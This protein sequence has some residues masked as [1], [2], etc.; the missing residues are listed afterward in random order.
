MRYGSS[1]KPV[2]RLVVITLACALPASPALTGDAGPSIEQRVED[3]HA[4]EQLRW[5]HR[6][7]PS[8]NP[9]PRPAYSAVVS[10]SAI[11]QAVLDTLEMSRL[12]EQRWGQAPSP[13]ELQGEL[14]RMAH[15]S[16]HPARLRELFRALDDDP[17]RI[18]ESL[19]RPLLVERRAR[20]HYAQDR[21]IHGPLQQRLRAALDASPSAEQLAQLGGRYVELIVRADSTATPARGAPAAGRQQEAFVGAI[22]W[23]RLRALPLGR[24]GPLVEQRDRFEVEVVLERSE[25][26]LRLGKVRWPKRSFDSWWREVGRDEAGDGS[27]LSVPTD[28]YPFTLPVVAATPCADPDSWTPTSTDANVPSPREDHTAV[29]TGSEMIV[30]GGRDPSALGSGGLYDPATDSWTPTSST[31][32][33]TPRFDHT[34]VWTGSAMIVWGGFG[35]AFENSGASYDPLGDSWTATGTVGAPSPRYRQTV[36]WT[37][38]EMIVWGGYDGSYLSSGGR[39][40]PGTQAWTATSEGAG[41][42]IARADH[43]AVWSGAEMIVW[44]G[45][46]GIG[47]DGVDSGG[48][49]DPT[50][51]S[52]VET[53]LLGDVPEPRQTHTI[54]SEP[55]QTAVCQ[56][57]IDGASVSVVAIQ[58]SV[59]GS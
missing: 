28:T 44:G 57:R 13:E 24:V 51:D 8:Q 33:P 34:A 21:R 39:Y 23:Q 53:S 37:G 19:A 10:D 35:S 17:R 38:S 6:L 11:R 58:L 2:V 30:W 54:I 9:G 41:S 1:L 18:V 31:G 29:W 45:L 20:E 50:G 52:W 56:R 32:A 59:E 16:K 7:W 46:D 5:S 40:E 36:V 14:D 4:L 27:E 12:L 3:R 49:Y 47:E 42:P 15:D 22:E 48:R 55:V 43:T 25:Q 26:A